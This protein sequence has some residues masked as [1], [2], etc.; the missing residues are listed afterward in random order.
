MYIRTQVVHDL[1]G[2]TWEECA[3][4]LTSQSGGQST[5]INSKVYYGGG[6]GGGDFIVHCYDPSQDNWTI[7][8][9]LPVR[10][11]GLGQINGKLVA[12]GGMESVCDG[13]VDISS[14]EVY[15]YEERAERWKQT[16]P[17]MPT[18]RHS[19]GT[20][21]LQS[22]LVVAGGMIV[23]Y[24]GLQDTDVVEV[25]KPDTS[26]WHT[27]DHDPLDLLT[28]Q[29]SLTV[30]GNTCYALGGTHVHLNE[31]LNA[32]VDDLFQNVVPAHQPSSGDTRQSAWKRIADTPAYRPTAAV[33]AGKLLAIGGSETSKGE[34]DMKE[35]YM[36]SPSANSWIYISDL[37][38]PRYGA[39][40]AVLSSTEI[41]VIGGLCG[42][43]R[44]RTVYKGTLQLKL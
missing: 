35:V 39:A 16:I 22:A 18:A 25:F 29:M 11:F 34:S 19:P 26:Q 38:A 23:D 32:S 31:A 8:P 43:S 42:D 41:L 37:P 2:I 17:S 12:V 5:V 6:Y 4:L 40:A 44:V 1:V 36:Y 30:I 24:E 15:T 28:S 9:P 14:N 33:L 3:Q 7:L 13:D 21:S 27:T 20:L 10:C